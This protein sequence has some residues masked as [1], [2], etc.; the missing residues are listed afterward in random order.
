MVAWIE[1]TYNLNK[2]NHLASKT[3][4]S[5][6]HSVHTA[7]PRY[8]GGVPGASRRAVQTPKHLAAM[9]AK[10]KNGVAICLLFETSTG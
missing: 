10:K 6:L 8:V 5:G 9:R 1:R 4:S 7:V 3:L 2:S